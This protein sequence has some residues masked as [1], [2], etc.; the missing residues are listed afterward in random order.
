MSS[1][2]EVFSDLSE[3][4]QYNQPDFPLY[5]RKDQLLRY[6]YAAACHWHPD[7]EFILV[8]DG[9]MDFF[10]NGKTV[11]INAHTGIFVNSRRLHYGFSTD[12]TNCSFLAAVIH[13]ILLFENSRTVKEYLDKKFGPDTD[14]FILLNPQTDWQQE[15][16]LLLRQI[17]D[18]MH[19]D[20]SNPLHLL[21]QAVILCAG[22]GDHIQQASGYPVEDQLRTIVWEM[23]GFIHR[24]YDTKISLDAI[25]ASGAVCKSRCCELFKKYVGQTPNNYLIKYRI[26]KSC[27]MLHETNRTI[28]EIAITCG[29]QS[30]SYFTSVFRKETGLTPQDYRRQTEASTFL[31]TVY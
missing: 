18:G 30:A 13:P 4:L 11:H 17:Y 27:E 9:A 23:T 21:S 14:D 25:A 6:G 16:L 5:V 20:N 3:R 2:L 8:L 26:A 29:F 1:P 19:E 15:A 31:D 24:H 12:K 22:M 10:V 28:C 7:L